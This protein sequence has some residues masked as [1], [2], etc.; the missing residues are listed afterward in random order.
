M[1]PNLSS[2]EEPLK[3]FFISRGVSTYEN[4]HRLG[5]IERGEPN[6]MTAKLLSRKFICK[7][8]L[9]T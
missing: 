1:L 9:Y 4:D 3:L 2:M 7:E 6:S 5:K 8:L